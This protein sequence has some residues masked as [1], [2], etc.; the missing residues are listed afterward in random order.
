MRR[1]T[2]ML[3]VLMLLLCSCEMPWEDPGETVVIERE[4]TAQE[5]TEER[6]PIKTVEQIIQEDAL[7]GIRGDGLKD[8]E[9]PVYVQVPKQEGITD[10]QRETFFALARKYCLHTMPDFAFGKK[11]TAEECERY[12]VNYCSSVLLRGDTETYIP[13]DAMEQMG[14][15]VF[16]VAFALDGDMKTTLGAI[17]LPMA[18][19]IYYKEEQSEGKTLITG[20]FVD[21]YFYPFAYAVDPESVTI[22][23]DPND[24]GITGNVLK[25]YELSQEENISFYEAAK[26]VVVS[27]QLDTVE[28][29]SRCYEIQ[30]YTEDGINPTEV[31]SFKT[32][33][34]E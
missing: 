34:L 18:E 14:K 25:A 16:N 32:T 20:K 17:A 6:E 22:T 15:E 31:V 10:A 21:H 11:P 29:A 13:K 12:A 3:L 23:Y 26:K 30:Y 33:I 8:P 9:G 24:A 19:L 4:E 1:L 28:R 27:G 5:E 7:N 2:A